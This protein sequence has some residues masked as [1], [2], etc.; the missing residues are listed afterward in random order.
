MSGRRSCFEN[1]ALSTDNLDLSI[2]EPGLY[3]IVRPSRVARRSRR[4]RKEEHDCHALGKQ[5]KG[6]SLHK[7]KD[8]I[9]VYN[10]G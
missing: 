2:R 10:K 6:D 4:V 9:I 7:S 5:E 1:G 3:L 8:K